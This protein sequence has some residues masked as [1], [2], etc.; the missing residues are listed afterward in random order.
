MQKQCLALVGKALAA[1]KKRVI[2]A[3]RDR[4]VRHR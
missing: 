3:R 2:H 4:L 1:I